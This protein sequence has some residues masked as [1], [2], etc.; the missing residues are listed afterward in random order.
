MSRLIVLFISLFALQVQ[1][2]ILFDGRFESGEIFPLTDGKVDSFFYGAVKTGCTF[3][4]TV[5]SNR[6]YSTGNNNRLVTSPVRAGTYANAQTTVRNCDYRSYNGGTLQKPRQ[7]LGVLEGSF[8]AQHN[9]EYWYGFSFMVPESY[10]VETNSNQ[11]VSLFQQKQKDSDAGTKTG[12][13]SSCCFAA[14]S[15]YGSTLR[16]G[17]E[18]LYTSGSTPASPTFD[19]NNNYEWALQKGKWNDVQINFKVCNI[20]EK[21]SGCVPFVKLY[22]NVDGAS[23]STPVAQWN[24]QANTTSVGAIGGPKLNVYRYGYNCTIAG[25]GYSNYPPT[26]AQSDFNFCKT[27]PNSTTN[28]V[29][30][31]IYFDEL[32]IGDANSSLQEI[33]PHVFGTSV[34]GSNPPSFV[35]DFETGQIQDNGTSPDGFLVQTFNG[36]TYVGVTGGGAGPSSGYDTRVVASESVGGSTVTPR[37]GTYFARSEVSYSKDYTAYSGNGGLDKPRSNIA[38]SDPGLRTDFDDENW[39]G[40]SVFLPSNFVHDTGTLNGAQGNQIFTN[41]A[42][43]TSSTQFTIQEYVPTGETES[44]WILQYFTDATS[45]KE[46]VGAKTTVDLGPVTGDLGKW[47]DFVI[48]YRMNPFTTATNA[49]TVTNGMNKV[50]EGNKG[51]LQ[52]WKASGAVDGNGNRT[53]TK[54]VDIV[55]APV[56][57]VPHTSNKMV[58][59]VRL[60]KYHWKTNTTAN[61]GTVW[62]GFDE[63]KAGRAADGITYNSV[64]PGTVPCTAGCGGTP[65]GPAIIGA[66]QG[67]PIAANTPATI[68]DTPVYFTTSGNTNGLVNAGIIS[69][70][71]VINAELFNG[72]ATGG[73]M[74]IGSLTGVTGNTAHLFIDYDQANLLWDTET[75]APFNSV[76]WTPDGMSVT[77]YSTTLLEDFGFTGGVTIANT[78]TGYKAIVSPEVEVVDGDRITYQCY[79]KAGTTGKLRLREY[80]RIGGATSYNVYSG[81]LGAMSRTTTG[82]GTDHTYKQY[83]RLGLHFIEVE[84]T[85]DAD[86]FARLSLGADSTAVGSSVIPYSCKAWKNR[87]EQRLTFP[88]ALSIPDT[89]NPQLSECSIDYSAVTHTAALGCNISEPVTLYS[90][91]TTS[92]TKPS[93]A[94]I[95][96]GKNSAGTPAMWA[97]SVSATGT[98]ASLT[99]ATLDP[100]VDRYAHFVAVDSAALQSVVTTADDFVPAE[101]VINKVLKLGTPT[102]KIKTLNGFGK[103]VDS[104]DTIDRVY[105]YGS[106]ITA[107]TGAVDPLVTLQNVVLTS[108][109]GEASEANVVP[110]SGSLNA[111]SDGSYWV[112][113]VE[114]TGSNM[115]ISY[116]QKS[117]V[118]E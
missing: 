104:N 61:T 38:M 107:T 73:R 54:V 21:A 18:G 49:S 36:S 72:N 108:G 97:G 14:L 2:A 74:A 75:T 94:Q 115:K 82:H 4:N 79:T 42:T 103:M 57:L 37:K 44:H 86:S 56:G 43:S 27:N 93:A 6:T 68:A 101:P 32:L 69:G 71:A 84:H 105:V 114:G 92:A 111:L 91:V 5:T 40:F 113:S 116:G 106:D 3:S 87:A 90:V 46:S 16:F 50:F 117:V 110:G 35:G 53:M 19:T 102:N 12:I 63:I 22:V 58:N 48:R 55:N 24:N 100:Y 34:P 20:N 96:E 11:V 76:S 89:A 31:T 109:I 118:T 60:Y 51:I 62:A 64:Y 59:A 88:V 10:N 39:L 80:R 99:S 8:N 26:S 15:L 13:S 70:N 9:V 29:S 23:S 85:V 30:T 81:T 33:A 77:P 65:T 95:I 7:E 83:S 1:A 112:L 45:T 28:P 67:L 17:V 47:T 78:E 41:Y 66:N 25:P 52:V 98:S